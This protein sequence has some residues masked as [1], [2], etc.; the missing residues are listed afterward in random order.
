MLRVQYFIEQQFYIIK[1][2]KITEDLIITSIIKQGNR[3]R[4][5]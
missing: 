1:Q 2:N 3:C 5:K 4:I